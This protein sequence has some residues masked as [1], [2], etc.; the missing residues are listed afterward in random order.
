M[1]QRDHLGLIPAKAGR[2]GDGLLRRQAVEHLLFHRFWP[3]G[4]ADGVLLP[5]LDDVPRRHDRQHGV[6]LQRDDEGTSSQRP[7]RR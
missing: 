3:A 2:Q 4:A 7:D 5:G 6:I 1:T